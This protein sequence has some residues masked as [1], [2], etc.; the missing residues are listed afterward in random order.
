MISLGNKG[1]QTKIDNNID[2]LIYKKISDINVDPIKS[3]IIIFNK[4]KI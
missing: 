4:K 2:F 3:F 1:F